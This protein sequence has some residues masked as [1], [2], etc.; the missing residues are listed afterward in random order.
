VIF[1]KTGVFFVFGN[2][3]FFVA[4]PGAARRSLR[5][6]GGVLRVLRV[7]LS[8]GFRG[9][10]LVVV[11]GFGFRGQVPAHAGISFDAPRP[12]NTFKVQGLRN[13][14]RLSRS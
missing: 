8:R 12:L 11:G 6:S 4:T 13:H 9:S 14:R 7:A 10:R 1:S 5:E 2:G 3:Y